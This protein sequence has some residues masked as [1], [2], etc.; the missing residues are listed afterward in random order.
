MELCVALKTMYRGESQP[1]LEI[2][3]RFSGQ[4]IRTIV[5]I[6]NILV[7]KLS[8]VLLDLTHPVFV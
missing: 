6:T 3:P 4:P 8:I 2:A 1:A 5:I 7:A